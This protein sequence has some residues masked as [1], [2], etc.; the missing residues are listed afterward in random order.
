MRCFIITTIGDENTGIRRHIDGI[1]DE[2]IIPIIQ[3]IYKIEVTHK[4]TTPGSINSQVIEAIYNADLVIANLTEL[5][6]NV[7]Y[8]LAFRHAI[9]KPLI[10][11][12]EYGETKI[13]FDNKC[14]KN[15]FLR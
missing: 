1:I 6:P 11:I 5:N 3:D 4:I 15:Y 8:E 12:M 10:M 9:R 13:S 7:M 2:C 14:R